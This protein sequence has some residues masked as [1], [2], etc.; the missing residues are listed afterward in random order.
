MTID[1]LPVA[2]DL[3]TPKDIFRLGNASEIRN[4]PLIRDVNPAASTGAA[5]AALIARACGA[6]LLPAHGLEQ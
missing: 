6:G 4:V 5:V 1:K 3:D 2:V